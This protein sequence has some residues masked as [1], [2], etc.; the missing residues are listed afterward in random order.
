M[1][2]GHFKGGL[3]VV[4]G[5]F[6]EVSRA[7]RESSKGVSGNI[8]G[9]FYKFLSLFQRSPKVVSRKFQGCFK[10][11]KGC[12]KCFNAVSRKFKDRC[13]EV[14]MVFQGNIKGVS[15]VLEG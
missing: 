8:E 1:F 9:S 13:K 6:K 12:F 7:F 14:S 11:I 4:K 3:R 10:N 5:Y 15:K 2:I